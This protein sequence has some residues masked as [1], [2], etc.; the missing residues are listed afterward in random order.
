MK[1][2]VYDIRYVI[3]RSEWYSLWYSLTVKAYHIK[4]ISEKDTNTM[5][6]IKTV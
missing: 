5:F 3:R 4:I 1:S 2:L 6:E